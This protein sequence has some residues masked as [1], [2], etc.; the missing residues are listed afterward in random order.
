MSKRSKL[1]RMLFVGA[2][3]AWANG[4]ALSQTVTIAAPAAGAPTVPPFFVGNNLSSNAA[5]I[6]S[7]TLAPCCLGQDAA[8]L[9][10]AAW[11]IPGGLFSLK[12]H[13]LDGDDGCPF[14]TYG[15]NGSCPSVGSQVCTPAGGAQTGPTFDQFV[16]AIDLAGGAPLVTLNWEAS[17]TE[18]L[19][20]VA[21]ANAPAP[22]SPDP[23]WTT[24][25]YAE[26]A[27]AP[28]GYFAWLR[29]Q[30]LSGHPPIGVRYWEL[31]NEI[32]GSWVCDAATQN[33]PS[34]YATRAAGLIQ[35][36][37]AIDSTSRVCVVGHSGSSWDQSLLAALASAG[38][39]PD[40]YVHHS[41]PSQPPTQETADAG[42]FVMNEATDPTQ[43]A[44]TARGELA[45]AFPGRSGKIDLLM[46][47]FGASSQA[48][49]WESSNIW[50][51]IF[52]ARTY[53][54][55]LA[56]GFVNVDPWLYAG[57]SG[58][59]SLI[60]STEISTGAYYSSIYFGA[61][62]FGLFAQG[63]G[64]VLA[65][66][67]A[68]A[69][70]HAYALRGS[71]GTTRVLLANQD[72][73]APAAVTLTFADVPTGSVTDHH[74]DATLGGEAL[75]SAATSRHP[76]TD[77]PAVSQ[78]AFSGGAV[79]VS[80]TPLDLELLVISPTGGGTTG[81]GTTGGGPD[82]GSSAAVAPR[83]CGCGDTSPANALPFLAGIIFLALYRQ[84]QATHQREGSAEA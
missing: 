60:D 16:Q 58:G 57:G 38:V 75:G 43:A 67:G 50:G 56:A 24:R 4:P 51:A 13:W 69:N 54:E 74:Y 31:G 23:S 25:S 21:Y 71:D 7:Q 63:G 45:S 68:Q 81:G 33:D 44:Q 66:S 37:H 77:Q 64:T 72:F 30:R 49:L 62:L 1:P 46:T 32:Y 78:L 11:R 61:S 84:R 2:L 82:G 76:L 22:A 15:P 41:Y 79:T 53:A 36:I 19:N 39:A 73:S 9:H 34:L 17:T 80:L 6:D 20:L 27:S 40:C 10:V 8:R 26:D 65:T 5:S 14:Q 55:A 83:G 12:W 35:S 29:T 18:M 47:E 52:E 3:L 28:A 42:T 48:T 59:L 70:V